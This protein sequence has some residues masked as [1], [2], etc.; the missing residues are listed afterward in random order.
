MAQGV[1]KDKLKE[2]VGDNPPQWDNAFMLTADGTRHAVNSG[3]FQLKLFK[4]KD[5][6]EV[7]EDWFDAVGNLG[8]DLGLSGGEMRVETGLIF[9]N[10]GVNKPLIVGKSK[11]GVIWH[12]AKLP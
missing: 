3:S 8:E 10:M 11:S 7:L 1:P 9:A 5:R 2:M 12:M 6:K 4:D